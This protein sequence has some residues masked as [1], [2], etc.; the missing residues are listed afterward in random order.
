[1]L[2]GWALTVVEGPVLGD[3]AKLRGTSMLCR[4]FS[5]FGFLVLEGINR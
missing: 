2:S 4:Q 5:T 1:M 3:Y